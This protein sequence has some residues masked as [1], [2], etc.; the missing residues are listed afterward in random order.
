MDELSFLLHLGDP[1]LTMPLG[2]ALLAWLLAARA[3]RMALCWGVLLAGGLGLVGV[4]KI[5]YLGWGGGVPLL[6]YKALSGH[7]AGAS[8][9]FPMLFWMLA[10]GRAGRWQGRALRLGLGIGV[11]TGALLV[12]DD[13]HSVAEAL[14]G[15]LLGAAVSLGSIRLGA[16]AMPALPWKGLLAGL[17]ALLASAWLMTWAHLGWWMVRAARLLTGHT[18]VYPL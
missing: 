4:S 9:V 17:A 15:C 11:L 6:G 10:H 13:Q 16:A 3:W 8:A 7:A 2:A 18:H 1:R 5:V 14:A 12:A